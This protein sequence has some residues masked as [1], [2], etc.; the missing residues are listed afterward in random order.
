MIIS[1]T[2]NIASFMATATLLAAA[3]AYSASL[4][5]ENSI[6]TGARN[7]DVNGTLLDVEF[8]DANCFEAFTG[9][10]EA[11]D[12]DFQ[13]PDFGFAAGQALLEQVLIDAAEGLFDTDP[14]LTLGC[15]GLADTPSATCFISFPVA[16]GN[17]GPDFVP[18][19]A[20]RNETAIGNAAG[21]D[22]VSAGTI[23]RFAADNP[24]NLTARFSIS[25]IP[26]PASVWMLLSVV[27]IGA[28]VARTRKGRLSGA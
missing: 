27:A 1:F 14:T 12:F 3:P 17:I 25:A 28:G 18:G 7:V 10:D 23:A 20:V 22:T 19:V 15:T 26:L 2:R 24:N 16:G 9:C 6:L 4:V 21:F 5:V 11:A 8:V 13:D